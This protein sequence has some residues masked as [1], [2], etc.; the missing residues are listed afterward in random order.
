MN[1]FSKIRTFVA[2]VS[3]L[4]AAGIYFFICQSVRGGT[5]VP[6]EASAPCAP[7][8][9]THWKCPNC[10]KTTPLDSHARFCTECGT[11]IAQALVHPDNCTK[12]GKTLRADAKFCTECGA[13]VESVPAGTTSRRTAAASPNAVVS[14]IIKFD[15]GV[16]ALD[17]ALKAM[18][19]DNATAFKLAEVLLPLGEK[20]KADCDA[21]RAKRE[22]LNKQLAVQTDRNRKMEIR[23]KILSLMPSMGTHYLQIKPRLKDILSADDYAR[24]D[25]LVSEQ[26]LEGAIRYTFDPYLRDWSE[27]GVILTEEQKTKAQTVRDAIRTAVSKLEIDKMIDDA[28]GI[29]GAAAFEF[30]RNV[31][32]ADQQRKLDR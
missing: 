1:K 29:A 25:K 7:A 15:S 3:L 24:L 13:K 9:P 32:T 12:C 4:A 14:G 16:Y 8:T 20:F 31:L 5:F 22:E 6:T 28:P 19:T 2:A 17:D 30:S 27:K 18:N 11:K 26:V 23:E 10:G 21:A